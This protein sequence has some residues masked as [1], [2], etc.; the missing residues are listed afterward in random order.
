MYYCTFYVCCNTT[1]A[2]DSMSL[3]MAHLQGASLCPLVRGRGLRVADV[4]HCPAGSGLEG[5]WRW[6]PSEERKARSQYEAE[7]CREVAAEYGRA[8]Y[9]MVQLCYGPVGEV[10]AFPNPWRLPSLAA[11]PSCEGSSAQLVSRGLRKLLWAAVAH[12]PRSRMPGQAHDLTR[13]PGL[14]HRSL[15]EQQVSTHSHRDVLAPRTR[16]FYIG[17]WS[18]QPW[19]RPMYTY[20][21]YI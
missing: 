17:T 9:G 8:E 19:K 12:N 20:V 13:E 14:E 21:H 4:G 3:R 11:P 6:Q 15:L 10:R 16:A 7:T 5:W 18:P 1:Q 2:I